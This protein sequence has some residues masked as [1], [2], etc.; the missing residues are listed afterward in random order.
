MK[1]LLH[2][3]FPPFCTGEA[4]A[5]RGV[6][7]R[8]IGHGHL[9]WR[10]IKGQ[11]PEDF[12]Y[13]LRVVS[14]ILESNGSSSMATTC[15]GTLALMD[16]GV[17]IK[18]PVAGIAM[19]LIKNPGEDKYAILSDILGDEDHLGDM[20]FKTT[21][22]VN[23]I[24]A[25]QMDIKCDGLSYEILEKALMQ[26]KA[27]REHIM[28]EMMKTISEPREDFKPH[29]P[30]IEQITIPKDMIG[31]VIGPGGKVIQQMQEET[32]TVI[33]IEEVDGVGKVQVSAP[34]RDAIQAAM[35][36]IKG[37][38][39]V[40]EVG[41]VY[42]STVKSIMPYGCFVE[43]L[44]GKEGLLH[45]SEIDWKRFE[46]MEETGLKEGDKIEVKLA[47]VDQKTGKFKLSHRVLLEKPEGYVE[48]PE[49]PQ[50]PRPERGDRPRGDRRE[51]R[52]DR[53][54]GDR[55]QRQEFRHS[56]FAK[57]DNEGEEVQPQDDAPA[58]D[59]RSALDDFLK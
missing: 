58:G 8:E 47:D 40:P 16:A 29:V 13:T 21:G 12:P 5:Q 9:A 1:F 50:R 54:R 30:R 38:V 32:G 59:V 26:A 46:T 52:P 49:R 56:D 10:G 14:D 27:G 2:Y 11:I 25:T 20:D 37:I 51:G 48:R 6:G 28:G 24:T 57:K 36:K 18:N 44:P 19:G 4:K 39:A 42:E 7:R 22:T 33:T 55:P 35:A 15:A 43:F 23:G 31:A 45:I 53:Q 17:P 41:E 34:N 3:N